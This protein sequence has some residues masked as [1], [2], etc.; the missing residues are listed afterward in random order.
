MINKK[1][2]IGNTPLYYACLS[3]K[4]LLVANLIKDGVNIEEK[5]EKNNTALHVLLKLRANH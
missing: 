5:N 4:L 1:D 2:E 3:G